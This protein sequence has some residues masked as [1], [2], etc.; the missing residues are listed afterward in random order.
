VWTL[1][2]V[3]GSLNRVDPASF[4]RTTVELDGDAA[5]IA[6]DGQD[7]YVAANERFLVRIDGATG[8]VEST[9]ALADE[10]IFRLR[11]AGFLAAARGDVWMT[12]PVVGRG[13]APQ[14]LWRIDAT[15]G[16]VTERYPLPGDPLTPLVAEGAV[17][18]PALAA[19]ALVR[20]DLASGKVTT[21]RLGDLPGFV[22]SGDGAIWVALA[23]RTVARLSPVDGSVQAT[24][25]VDTPAR[26]IAFGGDRVWVATEGGLSEIDPAT[27]T[28]VR[29]FRLVER[30]R[31]EGGTSVAFLD[32]TVWLSIE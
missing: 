14:T 8:T 15:T 3:A 4:D 7:V 25:A 20:V 27:N 23:R 18:V 19:T 12:I 28:V 29:E 21:I 10:R 31:D 11:D 26:G 24:I 16:A 13:S 32:G 17:W 6:S 1:D 5:A 9:V 2:F 22:A 30:R